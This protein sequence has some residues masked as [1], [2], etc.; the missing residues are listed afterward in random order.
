MSESEA[1]WRVLLREDIPVVLKWSIER[2]VAAG[3][4]W[5][6]HDSLS[7]HVYPKLS[8][9]VDFERNPPKG[10]LQTTPEQ[11]CSTAIF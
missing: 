8:I 4:R 9:S 3:E 1:E 6:A 2:L 11:R 7:A 10:C 5:A